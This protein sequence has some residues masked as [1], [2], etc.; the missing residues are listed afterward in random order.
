MRQTT[1]ALVYYHETFHIRV[2]FGKPESFINLFYSYILTHTLRVASST[3]HL[4]SSFF[5]TC[6]ARLKST[7]FIFLFDIYHTRNIF[8]FHNTLCRN[9]F[10]FFRNCVIVFQVLQSQVFYCRY[11]NR[12]NDIFFLW[13]EDM[14]LSHKICSYMP[15]NA[16]PNFF[17]GVTQHC[18]TQIPVAFN[19]PFLLVFYV[20]R[21]SFDFVS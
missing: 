8:F 16:S 15:S 9:R 12:S 11:A 13:I 21:D 10:H 3:V 17:S 2:I 5:A 6:H 7:S 1:T 14:L 4:L 19:F 18:L 20:S